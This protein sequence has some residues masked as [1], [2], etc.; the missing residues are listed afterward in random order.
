MKLDKVAS[1]GND[2]FYTP[3]YAVIPILKYLPKGCTVWLPFDKEHSRF[4]VLLKKMGLRQLHRILRTGM[5]SF[6]MCQLSLT[7]EL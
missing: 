1:S 4:N 5:T 6:I 2:E 7:M 3:D